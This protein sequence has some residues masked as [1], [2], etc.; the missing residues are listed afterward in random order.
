MI[1]L[2]TDPDFIR[3][4]RLLVCD[5]FC[6]SFSFF[7]SYFSFIFF[8]RTIIR[9]GFGYRVDKMNSLANK[10]I[11]IGR[12]RSRYIHAYIIHHSIIASPRFRI[13]TVIGSIYFI[14]C[15]YSNCNLLNLKTS[16]YSTVGKILDFVGK[17][18][19]YT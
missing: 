4:I 10:I 7:Q 8:F 16:Y 3:N 13:L 1:I 15:S 11:L 17:S 18:N 12:S 19:N 5:S 14:T 2:I 6:T 9:I